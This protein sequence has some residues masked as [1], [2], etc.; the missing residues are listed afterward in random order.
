[1]IPSLLPLVRSSTPP[2]EN[3]THIG[4]VTGHVTVGA[5]IRKVGGADVY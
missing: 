4:C 5:L 2:G 3:V 1:M